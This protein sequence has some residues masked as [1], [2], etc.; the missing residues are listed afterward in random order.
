MRNK[1][2]RI[3]KYH[4]NLERIER[5]TKVNKTKTL[6]EIAF[7]LHIDHSVIALLSKKDI[8]LNVDKLVKW[9]D[10]IPVTTKLA[11]TI[12]ELTDNYYHNLKSRQVEH[13]PVTTKR[14]SKKKQEPSPGLFKRIWKAI[15]NK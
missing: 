2:E 15:L 7:N 8:L 12:I 14:I 5:Y 1:L 3:K 4:N 13:V 11:E 10:K 6:S 9:N